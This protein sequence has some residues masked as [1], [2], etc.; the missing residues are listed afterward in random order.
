ML[1]NHLELS[2]E[3]AGWGD[4]DDLNIVG[5]L[6]AV[7]SV[8]VVFQ[9]ALDVGRVGVVTLDIGYHPRGITWALCGF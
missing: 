6:I 8:K 3:L 7:E 2:S 5:I 9:G 4:T 1:T